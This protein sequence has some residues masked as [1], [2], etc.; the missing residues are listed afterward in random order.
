MVVGFAG[1]I[2]SALPWMLRHL[3]RVHLSPFALPFSEDSAPQR[4][5]LLKC[6]GRQSLATHQIRGNLREFGRTG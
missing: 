1:E 5:H 2:I 6:A 3:S 4:K